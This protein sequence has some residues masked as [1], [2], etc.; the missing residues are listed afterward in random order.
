M[1]THLVTTF[2]GGFGTA[3]TALASNK[4][5]QVDATWRDL[6]LLAIATHKIRRIATKDRVTSSFRAPFARLTGDSGSGEVEESAR[7]QGLQRAM[8]ELV[9]C[10]FCVA[11][12]IASTLVLLFKINPRIT[13]SVAVVF[14]VVSGSDFLNRSITERSRSA[15]PTKIMS[16]RQNRIAI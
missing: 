1:K 10:P 13:R 7:G 5:E 15:S 9:T 2:L 8:G 6:F 12:W 11:P 14:S 3:F 4:R 16:P